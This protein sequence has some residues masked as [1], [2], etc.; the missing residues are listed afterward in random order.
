MCAENSIRFISLV[1]NS[2]HLCKPLDV[3]FFRAMKQAWRS[4]LAE[5]KS[6]NPQFGTI[7]KASFPTL[8]RKCLE[9]MDVVPSEVVNEAANETIAI[10]RKFVSAFRS[11]G[12]FPVDRP[13]IFKRFLQEDNESEN[14]SGDAESA[15]V[16]LLKA[17]RFNDATSDKPR[18]KMRLDVLLGRSVTT[19]SVPQ[20]HSSESSVH[21]LAYLQSSSSVVNM[22]EPS[23][24][25]TPERLKEEKLETRVEVGQYIS[26]EFLST[27]GKK[28]TNM[29]VKS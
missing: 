19:S 7:S 16:A 25:E 20:P 22:K 26:A 11:A 18:R 24:F 15:L 4:V 1:P 17:K 6:Q 5:W 28:P 13:Q 3:S 2:T 9:Q 14:A 12:V 8:L 27:K 23:D 10:K 21:S 29:C